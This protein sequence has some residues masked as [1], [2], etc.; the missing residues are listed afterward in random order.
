[1][2]GT[3]FVIQVGPSCSSFKILISLRIVIILSLRLV[4][5]GLSIPLHFKY[6]K[7]RNIF[8]DYLNFHH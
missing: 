7:T 2:Q 8:T 4:I 3:V 5:H 1:M 6:I